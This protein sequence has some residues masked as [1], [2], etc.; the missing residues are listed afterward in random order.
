MT[1]RYDF[2]DAFRQLW[3]SPGFTAAAVISLALGIG[4]NTAIFTLLDQVLLRALPVDQ[5]EELVRL[6]I[7]GMR[8]GVTMGGGTM[9]YP[10]YRDIR[11]QNQVFSGVLCRYRVPLSVGYEGQTE[12]VAGELVSGNYFDTLRIGTAA[13]R[14]LTPEDDRQ[15]GGHPLAMLS[16][17]YWTERFGADPNV[18]GRVLVVNGLPLTIV[19]VGQKGFDG[20]ELG[21]SPRLWIPVAMKAQMTQG[22]FS[23][24]VTLANRRNLLGAGARQTETWR[25]AEDR[26]V[27]AS[28]IV[29]SRA[30][31]GNA[32]ARV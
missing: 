29:P 28:A 9:S 5:P 13:G 11:D 2:R 30:R 14:A 10:G 23:E 3:R 12:R 27:V 8:Y 4:A 16:Y 21:Y 24:A 32:R 26:A 7:R 18:V 25:V 20:I 22:W 17:D 31:A 1:I 15:P 6:Q 19:G